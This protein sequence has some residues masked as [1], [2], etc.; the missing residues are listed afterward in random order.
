[1]S[2]ETRST[3][4]DLGRVEKV[5]R[6]LDVL[7]L[8]QR[9]DLSKK[10]TSMIILDPLEEAMAFFS[11][12]LFPLKVCSFFPWDFNLASIRDPTKEISI[13]STTRQICYNL[14]MFVTTFAIVVSI[15][16]SVT[17]R[18]FDNLGFT[19]FDV[20]IYYA[21]LAFLATSASVGVA[22]QKSMVAL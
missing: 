1:M 3:P 17:S 9:K 13:T 15:L 10:K 18:G 22:G 5:I 20:V 4:D 14:V 19:S 16:F 6:R 8:H 21:L 11:P 12:A 2:W 7:D